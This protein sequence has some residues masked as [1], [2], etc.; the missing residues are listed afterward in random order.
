MQFKS[1]VIWKN[2]NEF[3]YK[4]RDQY[5]FDVIEYPFMRLVIQMSGYDYEPSKNM[6]HTFYENINELYNL[7]V[8][9][10]TMEEEID[11][12]NKGLQLLGKSMLNNFHPNEIGHWFLTALIIDKIKSNGY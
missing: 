7:K 3:H 5:N 11:K 9:I 2:F 6:E 12:Q 8:D 4:E 10:E 1:T